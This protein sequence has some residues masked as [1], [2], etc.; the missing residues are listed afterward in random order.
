MANVFKF[1][2]RIISKLSRYN[3]S[4]LIKIDIFLFNISTPE[5]NPGEINLVILSFNQRDNVMTSFFSCCAI[6]VLI[7]TM[8][9][10]SFTQSIGC[11]CTFIIS[12]I[13]FNFISIFN[14]CQNFISFFSFFSNVNDLNCV[15]TS[16]KKEI[17]NYSNMDIY[18]KIL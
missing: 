12:D 14:F 9:F 17:F 6:L 3:F 16:I 4:I 13:N 1:S 18:N 15:L 7:K 2:N 5:V 8:Q 11:Y 10:A